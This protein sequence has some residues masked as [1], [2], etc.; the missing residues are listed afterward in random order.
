M[1]FEIDCLKK[2]AR[3]IEQPP[4]GHKEFE[5][6]TNWSSIPP[7]SPIEDLYENLCGK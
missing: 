5:V 2:M 7:E 4:L 1:L 6:P 3:V